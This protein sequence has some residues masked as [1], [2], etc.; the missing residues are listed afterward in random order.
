[1]WLAL[2]DFSDIQKAGDCNLADEQLASSPEARARLASSGSRRDFLSDGDLFHYTRRHFDL[3]DPD[4]VEAE[5]ERDP[6]ARHRLEQ[7]QENIRAHAEQR[8][9]ERL[10]ASKSGQT[11]TVS[12]WH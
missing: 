5:L 1:M 7:I 9:L 12:G 10:E 3:V 2:A 8:I 11:D 6:V 4:A